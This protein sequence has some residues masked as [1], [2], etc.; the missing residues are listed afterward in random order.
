MRL[1]ND[2][3]RE[4]SPTW[5]PD[6]RFI[7]FM[8]GRGEKKGF[9]IIPALG[10]ADRKIADAFEWNQAGVR[11]QAIDW[12]PD[13]NT[14]AVIDKTSEGEPWSVFLLSVE[15]G[16]KRKLTTPPAQTNGDVLLAFSPDGKSLAFT[17]TNA[18]NGNIFIVPVAGGE[19]SQITFD[20]AS[21]FSE[22]IGWAMA[23]SLC[24]PQRRRAD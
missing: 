2:A 23:S 18:Q 8:R 5:S 22:W 16:E 21:N 15:T 10:G 24:F 4:M 17:R 14:L 19:P 7:A 6:G 11:A 3:Q 1:T 13:G 20:D 9:Y 12:S